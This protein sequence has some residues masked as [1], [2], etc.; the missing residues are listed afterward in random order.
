MLRLL[1]FI[2]GIILLSPL[3][4]VILAHK[5]GYHEP[6]DL[7]IEKLRL[8]EKQSIEIPT[9]FNDYSVP[10]LNPVIGYMI[11]GFIGVGIIWG[12]GAL[13]KKFVSRKEA[14]NH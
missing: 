13:L 2:I 5:T 11:S 8:S 9:L 14:D 4:G 1:V 12:M 6:L 7:V 10:G 3:F